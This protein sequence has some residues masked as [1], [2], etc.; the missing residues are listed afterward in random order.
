VMTLQLRNPTSAKRG[1]REDDLKLGSWITSEN[2]FSPANLQAARLAA[3]FGL[4]RH[5][6]M[7]VAGLA[8]RVE[9]P[10]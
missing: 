7:A 6:A 8:F 3:R 5:L 9:A 10:R 4:S 1:A 2:S